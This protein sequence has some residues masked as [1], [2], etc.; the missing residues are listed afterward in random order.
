MLTG[1]QGPHCLPT[2]I[3]CATAPFNGNIARPKAHREL[4]SQTMSDDFPDAMRLI[5][6]SKLARFFLALLKLI[7]N[8]AIR[9]VSII[10][11]SLLHCHYDVGICHTFHDK[12]VRSFS[13]CDKKIKKKHACVLIEFKTVSLVNISSFP[14]LVLQ[15]VQSY[16][17]IVWYRFFQLT[18]SHLKQ[19]KLFSI[20]L[21]Y[22]LMTSMRNKT[23]IVKRTLFRPG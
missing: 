23:S 2:R 3:V 12:M 7:E 20:I 18:F 16:C 1:W 19:A 15:Y 6:V 9:W 17:Q 21:S 14:R 10:P 13:N 22:A 8:S 5:L 4:C 11:A